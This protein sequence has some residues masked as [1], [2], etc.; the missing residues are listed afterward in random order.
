MSDTPLTVDI[1]KQLLKDQTE[2][3]RN[4]MNKMESS[5]K[6]EIKKSEEQ[7][8]EHVEKQL[9]E[10]KN[11]VNLLK[12]SVEVNCQEISDLRNQNDRERRMRN[13]VIFKIAEDEINGMQLKAKV[14]SLIL[15]GCKVDIGNHI[16]R[17]YRIG[18]P[19]PE[20]VR[21]ILLSL[22]S[23]DKKMEILWGK[24]HHESTLQLADDYSPEV[25]EAR[26]KLVPVLKRLRELEYKDVHLKQDKLF[27]GGKLCEEEQWNQLLYEENSEKEPETMGSPES[28]GNGTKRKAND[29]LT[30]GNDKKR[31]NAPALP[32]Q[33]PAPASLTENNVA[34]KP[35]TSRTYLTSNQK[36]PTTPIT[37]FF[38]QRVV[39]ENRVPSTEMDNEL[40]RTFK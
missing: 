25:L 22:T 7:V 2:E 11:D 34:S 18:K 19:G 33:L 32:A 38:T 26:R 36:V 39:A 21:P 6:D 14:K 8:K 23:F 16:D 20:K 3:G 40:N 31:V 4:D 10:V 13:L 28:G 27:V 29:S 24:K 15:D 17:I 5:L 35:E 37:K 30:E 12:Q 1:L 9:F